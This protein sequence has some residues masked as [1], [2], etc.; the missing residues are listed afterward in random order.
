MLRIYRGKL[1]ANKCARTLFGR[2]LAFCHYYSGLFDEED[3]SQFSGGLQI[4]ENPKIG[5]VAKRG[6]HQVV[7]RVRI[8]LE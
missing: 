3:E 8:I 2:G 4:C 1:V 5:C 7:E 6:L